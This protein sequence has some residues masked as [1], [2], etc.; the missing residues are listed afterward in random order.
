MQSPQF[1]AAHADADLLPVRMCNELVYCERLF[2]LEHVQGIFVDSADTINGRAEH[3]RAEQNRGRR[4]RS[5]KTADELPPWPNAPR[6]LEFISNEWGIRGKIDFLEVEDEQAIV[7]ETKHGKPPKPGPQKWQGLE[8][9][10]GAWPADTAQ[11]GLYLAMLREY[12][13]DAQVGRIYYRASRSTVSIEWSNE[14]ETFLHAV[15]RRA[16]EVGELTTPP[17]PLR[18]SPKCPGCSLHE[19]CLP[20]EHFS[21]Q[22][23]QPPTRRLPI[24]RDDRYVVHVTTPGSKVCKDGNA[25]R[26]EPREGEPTRVLLK[27]ISHVSVFGPSQITAQCFGGLLRDGIG[28]SHHTTTGTLLGVSAPIATRNVGL[29]RAQYRAADDPTKCIE[30]ARALVVAKLRNQRTV[31]RRQLRQPGAGEAALREAVEHMTLSVRWA[32]RA[33]TLDVLR[34]YEGDAARSYFGALPSTLPEDWRADLAGR[35]RRP[36]RDRVNAMLSF[37]YSLLTREAIAAI[38]RVGLDPMLGFFHSM[39][40]GR[41]ALALDL[42][43]PFRPAWSDTAVLRLISTSG[44]DRRDFTVIP[45]A[46]YLN[47]AGRKKL[48]GAHERRAR[49]ETSHPRFDYRMSYR[50][51]LE[52]EVRVLSKFL[53]GEIDEYVPI[54]TR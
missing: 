47:N 11:I 18:D 35:S 26:I 5:S 7:V 2:H 43:E 36:P 42:I 13:L 25:L 46:V 48:I 38:G 51:I 20:D 28:V 41:P 9:P 33:A 52:L 6:S 4:R 40:P 19:V 1:T 49:E 54:W 27:D 24:A 31:L 50:R 45:A 16:Q 12:G 17:E 39:V 32:E 53:A 14:L 15:L 30:V 29:R 34:G 23:H 22:E 44:I 21:L 3:E 8:L 10:E 37:A